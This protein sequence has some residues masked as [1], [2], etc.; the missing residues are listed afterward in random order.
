MFQVI[1]RDGSKADFTLTKI[2]DAIMKA[3]TATQ[4]SYNNDIID[5]LAL[6]VTADF[7]K[8]VENDEIHVEDIQDSVEDILSKAGYA[9]VAKA[10]GVDSIRCST[11][12][13]FKPALEKAIE[14]NKAGKPFLV[15]AP[16]ENIV[17]PT[18]GCWNINDIYSP[19]ELVKEGKLVK[20]E[21]G[22]YV[23]PSHSKSH[24]A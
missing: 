3:F 17:V 4:M 13:E 20:K 22:Q 19:N 21:N 8:K 7:Q 18:P 2:N 11:A 14:A 24:D 15:E 12:D 16:M 1:K 9:D 10:Y 6:R 5:L 23:A